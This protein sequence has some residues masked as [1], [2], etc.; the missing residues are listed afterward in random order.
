MVTDEEINMRNEFNDTNPG[1]LIKV[2]SKFRLSPSFYKEFQIDSL[3]F[4][5]YK[6][7]LVIVHFCSKDIDQ[8]R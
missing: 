2:S 7:L 1:R 3:Q 5:F 6:E 8:W 4:L